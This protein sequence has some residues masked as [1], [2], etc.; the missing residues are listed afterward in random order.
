MYGTIVEWNGI[1]A[2]TTQDDDI[3]A[4]EEFAEYIMPGEEHIID[5]DEDECQGTLNGKEVKCTYVYGFTILH[6][7]G[8]K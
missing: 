4:I 1:I 6:V 5:Y 2:A 7:G 8:D 3:S